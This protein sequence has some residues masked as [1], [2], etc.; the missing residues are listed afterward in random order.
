MQTL[1]TSAVKECLDHVRWKGNGVMKLYGLEEASSQDINKLQLQFLDAVDEFYPWT[2]DISDVDRTE[3]SNF[4]IKLL[5]NI[6]A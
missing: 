3:A 4:S 5:T 1:C 2:D 6:K